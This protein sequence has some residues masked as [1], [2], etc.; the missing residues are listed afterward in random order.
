[1][2]WLLQRGCKQTQCGKWEVGG[3]KWEVGS[4]RWEV[5]SGK[6]EVGSSLERG[7]KVGRRYLANAFLKIGKHHLEARG[8]LSWAVIFLKN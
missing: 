4:W 7:A 3:G 2:S 8:L 6:W 5:G 1:L